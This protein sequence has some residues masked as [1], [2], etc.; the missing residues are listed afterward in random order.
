MLFKLIVVAVNRVWKQPFGDI[1]QNRC[2]KSFFTIFT[3]KHLCRSLFF[4]KIANLKPCNAIKRLQYRSLPVKIA[5]FL[6]AVFF[7][8]KNSFCRF[9]LEKLE[10][11]NTVV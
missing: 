8:F 9:Y 1:L 5:K 11:S 2:F 3:G 6:R 7:I 4:N 10:L